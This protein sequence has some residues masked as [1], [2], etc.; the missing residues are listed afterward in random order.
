MNS[1]NRNMHIEISY[2][3]SCIN[4]TYSCHHSF[5][6]VIYNIFSIYSTFIF[7]SEKYIEKC[8]CSLLQS[9]PIENTEIILVNDGSK[10]K[11]IDIAK[12]ILSG[13]DVNYKIITQ[14]NSGVSVARNRGIEEASGEYI[15]FLD[16]DDY[17]DSKFVELMYKKSQETQSDVVYCGGIGYI[18]A[19]NNISFD[20]NPSNNIYQTGINWDKI[21]G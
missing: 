13:S 6:P 14:K 15:T 17:I 1:C 18:K 5:K 19:S 12:E 16:S 10:D 3:I 20:N 21:G 11:S 4:I 8:V 9:A 2:I 7:N